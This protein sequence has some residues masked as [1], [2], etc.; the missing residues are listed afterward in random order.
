[1]IAFR[2]WAISRYTSWLLL[3]L[4][5]PNGE[6][7]LPCPDEYYP[8]CR[9]AATPTRPPVCHTTSRFVG[10]LAGCRRSGAGGIRAAYLRKIF[11]MIS[12]YRLAASLVPIDFQFEQGEEACHDD[13]QLL[14]VCTTNVSWGGGAATTASPFEYFVVYV[15]CTRSHLAAEGSI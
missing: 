5:A 7:L 4:C 14:L 8:L 6:V 10:R 15:Y 3:C 2:V 13:V 12:L 11:P 1:V 9:G